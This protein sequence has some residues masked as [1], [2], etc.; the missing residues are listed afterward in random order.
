MRYQTAPRPVAGPM[1]PRPRTP[2]QGAGDGN[3]TR[4]RSLE[5][6]C[7]T[8]TLRP[9]GRPHSTGAADALLDLSVCARPHTRANAC[10]GTKHLYAPSRGPRHATGE[11]FNDQP[12]D[13]RADD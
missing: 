13:V 5:G 1:L 7:A 3:R 11:G 10:T 4:P 2:I 6:F 9:R 12:R 8:T